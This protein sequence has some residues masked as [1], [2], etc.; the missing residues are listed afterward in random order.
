[1]SFWVAGA[2][3]GSSYLG[4]R[5]SSNA[6]NVQAA[7]SDRAAELAS[8]TAKESLEAQKEQFNRTQALQE[9]LYT[10][11]VARQQP[12][13]TAG[14]NALA[15]MQAGESGVPAAF[16]YSG[17]A[18]SAFQYSGQ[19]PAA[20]KFTADQMQVDPGYAFRLSEGQ[21]ALDRQAA[22]RGGLIS[23]SALKAATRYGQ[24]MGSQEYQNAY[25]RG[26]T[27]Y[28]AAAAR[29]AQQY[30][31][32]MDVYN[33]ATARDAQQYARAVDEYNAKVQQSN[34]GF[35]RLASMAGI[36]QTATGQLGALG[37]SYGGNL[38]ASGQNYAN[39]I[40]NI[41]TATAGNIGNLMTSGAAARASGYIGGANAITGGLGTYLNY[42][43][44][45]NLLGA[46]QNQNLARQYG[47]A[48]VYSPT[49][50]NTYLPS[51]TGEP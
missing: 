43:Q 33:A 12:W 34:T 7:S 24:D 28:N 14:T 51:W 23:G 10:E 4:N 49:G 3:V 11:G 37:Q 21:K 48:N 47:A 36:G 31:R 15:R 39:A 35:N 27:E 45:N 17:Q 22:A 13:L 29:E 40:G 46:L 19:A 6:A 41:N 16:Q 32:A 5:A 42:N 50:G 38:S 44:S 8:Q 26:L 20:F 1:M 25:N 30:G 9:R 2:I 18:P